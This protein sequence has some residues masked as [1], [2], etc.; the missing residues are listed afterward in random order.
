MKELT[1]QEIQ[2]ETLSIMK[3]IH[4]ICVEQNL[5]YSL[6]YGTLIGAI[7]HNG[8][9]PW[10]DDLDIYM[11]RTDYEK[12]ADYFVSHKKELSPLMWFSYETVQNYPY[13]ITRICNTKFTM[14]SE[15]EKKCGMGTF[16]DIYPLDGAW[17]GKRKF[18]YNKAWFYSS[19]Y[20]SKSRIHYVK[21]KGML[22]KIVKRFSYFLSKF[23][24]KESIRKKLLK[25]S[26][27]Y[28]YNKSDVVGCII[29]GSNPK[30]RTVAKRT[31]F[32]NLTLH[33]FED[34]EFYIFENYD[35]I[36]K[37]EYGDYMQLPPESERVG[38]HF[39]KIY[40]KED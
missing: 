7:R 13:L 4:S 19:M 36:L 15:N 31:D 26:K 24:S 10:D 27:K 37:T 29:W 32:D 8:F 22:K 23:Y 17:D 21:P 39:Y 38:H 16:V 25:F 1:L 20:F 9:I 33:K 18:F 14:E 2:L 40:R 12:L 6:A 34:T 35:S 30:T 3:K 28:E 11:P 5:K